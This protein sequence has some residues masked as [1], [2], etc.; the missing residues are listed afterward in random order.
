MKKLFLI[1]LLFVGISNIIYAKQTPARY[2]LLMDRDW[3]FFLGDDKSAST[4]T[5]N[6]NAWRL[7]D[8]P[9]DWSIEGEF[10]KDAPTKGG[11]GYLPTGIGWYRKQFTL[12]SA[13]KGKQVSIQFDGVYMNSEVWINGHYLGKR[14]YGYISFVYDLTP[15]LVAGK[16]TLAVRVDNSKQPNSRWYSGSGIYRHVW[17]NITNPL[18]IAQWGTYVTTPNADVASATVSIK[19]KIENSS[20]DADNATLTSIIQ[21]E[22]GHEVATNTIP[23]SIT[24]K[25][26]GEFAQQI[27]VISPVLW[28]VDAPHLYTLHSIIKLGKRIVDD[29]QS[30]FGIRK[31]EYSAVNGF[32]LNGK[33]VKMNGVCLHHD[34]GAVGA[35]VPIKIWETR[36]KLL[37]QMGCNA[38]RTSHNPVAPEFLDLCDKMGFLVMD[39]AFDAW[40]TGK[41]INDYNLY[42]DEWSQIDVTDQIHR[43][44][45]HPSVVLWSAGNEIPD[46][47]KDKGVDLLKGL[48]ATFHK[49]DPTRPVTTANDDIAADSNS[50]KLAFMQAEDVVGYNYVDRW[51]ERRE[52]FYSID[53]IDHP[54]WKV[55]GTESESL[56]NAPEYSL[57]TDMGKVKA[58]YTSGMVRTEQLWKFVSVHD[59][60]IGDFMWTGIDY[61]GE[62]RWPGKGSSSGEIDMTN[63]P[64]DGYYFYQSQWTNKPVLHLLPHWNWAGRE[65]QIIPVL[66]YT[67]CDT[68]ELFVNGKSYGIK[69][70]EFPRQGNSGK[71]NKYD[72]PYVNITTGDIHLSWDVAYEPGTIKAVGRKNGKE[73]IID[74]IH[75]AGKPA[76]L[77]LITDS[78]RV[79]ADGKDV[80]LI[81][82]DVI[83]DQGNV[84]PD[85]TNIINF[86][87]SGNGKL[88]G[89]DNGD[90]RDDDSFKLNHRKAFKG[91]AYA[92]V[93]TDS[94]AGNINIAVQADGL[95]P[96]STTI[97]TH[98]E[99]SAIMAFEDFK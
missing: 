84:V 54:E 31:V 25:T 94:K 8:L 30:T 98:K 36:L 70:Q 72:K 67:N 63:L 88:I 90:Q 17:M 56:R 13:A 59:Y 26:S 10:D 97:Q 95:K 2:H 47:T 89:V 7:L 15:Y 3:R 27:Q 83:D 14:P 49:E 41:V 5:F 58:N 86:T 48:L 60:V 57:G 80:A 73:V 45:N 50:T 81:H 19:T 74:E 37:K 85:A 91:H 44:R 38:I 21:D 32:M 61:L 65:G 71:W 40:E 53:K 66:A 92:I 93:Q 76:A 69:V 34:G 77:R 78:S 99:S 64:K 9:H 62:A 24:G 96:A 28:S 79:K 22:N 29:F 39:E 12:P 46:Q 42:F 82:V 51:H 33:R 55:I 16:N 4:A 23:V 35:A 87:V 75:T 18:H 20:Q 6:D 1:T 52:L 68:V 11:G 43:D